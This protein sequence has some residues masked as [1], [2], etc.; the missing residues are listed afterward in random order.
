MSAS[1][2]L[3]LLLYII[4]NVIKADE[5]V[6]VFVA[7]QLHVQY[8]ELVFD[9]LKLPCAY[10]YSAMDPT[11]RRINAAKFQKK[12]S[13]VLIAT[14]IA[15]RGIDIPNLDYVINYNFPGTSKVFVHR[16][17]RA[18]RAGKSGVAFSFVQADEEPYLWD[19]HKFLGRSVKFSPQAQSGTMSSTFELDMEPN[20][21]LKNNES[22]DVN[23]NDLSAKSGEHGNNI[24]NYSSV[25]KSSS[26][27]E[28]TDWNFQ[29][30]NIPG[31]I[32]GEEAPQLDRFIGDSDVKYLSEKKDNAYKLYERSRPRP[33]KE[34]RREMNEMK[35]LISPGVHPF[36]RES[37]KSS[38]Y[39]AARGVTDEMLE[40]K[41][42]MMEQLKNVRPKKVS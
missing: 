13:N 24:K 25:E 23:R 11:S 27:E 4:R 15:A 5:Q 29:F 21:I 38:L 14:D 33:S 2:K 19:L 8:L 41:T 20:E 3:H 26:E 36:L 31:D 7:T 39:P 18:A 32:I 30:G 28:K 12:I 34:A 42:L 22:D 40:R 1:Y 16:V 35:L 10:L 17:G 37:V 6:I 9:K